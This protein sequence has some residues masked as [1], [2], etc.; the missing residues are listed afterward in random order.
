MEHRCMRCRALLE[1]DEIALYR[2]LIRREAKEYLCLS[3]L[4]G[5]LSSTPERLRDL[6]HYYRTRQRCCLFV[7]IEEDEAETLV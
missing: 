3:C 1:S 6:I 4:A 2:K 5:D 7:D